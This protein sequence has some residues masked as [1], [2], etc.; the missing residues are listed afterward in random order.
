MVIIYSICTRLYSGPL[1]FETYSALPHGNYIY[2]DGYTAD[3]WAACRPLSFET[4]SA[5]PHGNYK[6]LG[7]YTAGGKVASGLLPFETYSALPHGNY[8]CRRLYSGRLGGLQT[9]VL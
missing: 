9:P 4:Y 1:S 3:G 7:G 2:V 5:L 8:I 6:Y